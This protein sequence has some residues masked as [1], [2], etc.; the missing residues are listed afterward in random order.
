M[1]VEFLSFNDSTLHLLPS[2]VLCSSRSLSLPNNASYSESLVHELE[3]LDCR[4]ALGLMQSASGKDPLNP[5]RDSLH[6]VQPKSPELEG[7]MTSVCLACACLTGLGSFLMWVLYEHLL[8]LIRLFCMEK[9]MYNGRPK[10]CVG[11]NW[12]SNP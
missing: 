2:K 4:F 3:V 8:I 11:S 1:F 10:V 7:T 6:S 12:D 5:E 9:V